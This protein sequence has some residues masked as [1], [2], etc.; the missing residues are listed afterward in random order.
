MHPRGEGGGSTGYL[1]EPATKKA[2]VDAYAAMTGVP[3]TDTEKIGGITVSTELKCLYNDETLKSLF[4]QAPS[5]KPVSKSVLCSR[6]IGVRAHP[7]FLAASGEKKYHNA[8]TLVAMSM[9]W[10]HW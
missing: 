4:D 1:T 6:T 3:D 9:G 10:Q 5:D 7:A 8:M 2:R